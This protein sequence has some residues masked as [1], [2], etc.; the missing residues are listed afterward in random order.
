MD[1]KTFYRTSLPSHR[2]SRSAL[3]TTRIRLKT[4]QTLWQHRKKTSAKRIVRS[5]AQ[6]WDRNQIRCCS[7]T[8]SLP[9]ILLFALVSCMIPRMRRRTFRATLWSVQPSTS[10][11]LK[12]ILARKER[13]CQSSRLLKAV[14]DKEFAAKCPSLR[15]ETMPLVL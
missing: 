1:V 4:S 7:S 9:S 12:E 5:K 2:S 11:S 13:L 3:C 6:R 14:V 10:S 15:S 8:T